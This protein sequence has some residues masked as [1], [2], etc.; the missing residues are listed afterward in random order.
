[1]NSLYLETD[2]LLRFTC[3]SAII[4][5]SIVAVCMIQYPSSLDWLESLFN[6]EEEKEPTMATKPVADKKNYSCMS[7]VAASVSGS[8]QSS[9][10]KIFNDPQTTSPSSILDIDPTLLSMLL[11]IT[12]SDIND[13]EQPPMNSFAQRSETVTTSSSS[14]EDELAL[15]MMKAEAAR[16]FN[17][18]KHTKRLIKR[19]SRHD[20]TISESHHTKKKLK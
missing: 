14:F 6:I 19:L 17:E 15:G 13:S 8:P 12:D 3:S 10:T 1:M 16:D 5:S 4:P 20:S 18:W 11:Q 2:H 7:T 9:M